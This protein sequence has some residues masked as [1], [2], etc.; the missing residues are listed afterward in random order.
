MGVHFNPI[1]LEQMLTL[2]EKIRG[3]QALAQ[4]L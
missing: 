4:V 3:A 1:S 2:G